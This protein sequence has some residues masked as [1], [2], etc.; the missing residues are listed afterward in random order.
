MSN[1]TANV[2]R[3]HQFAIEEY[4]SSAGDAFTLRLPVER[5]GLR[6]QTNTVIDE[7]INGSLWEV[8]DDEIIS[9]ELIS[10]SMVL[11]PRPATLQKICMCIFGDGAFSSNVKLPG[12]ICSY[13]QVGHSDPTVDKIYRYNNCVTSTAEFSASD[14]SPLLSLLWNIEGQS[15]TVTD[16]V[17]TNWPS[18]TLSSQ[19]PFVFRQG[20]LTVGGTA[21]K[22]KDFRFT[23]N[24]NLQLGDFYNSLNREE[25]PSSL[26]Q[27]ELIHTSP[28]DSGTEAAKIGTAQTDIAAT[29]NFVSGTKQLQFEFPSLYTN[30]DEPE[31][32]GRL[33]IHNQYTWRAKY[34]SADAIAA[35]VRITVVES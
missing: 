13:F 15:R 17:S 28:W 6:G 5:F 18:L 20:T 16:D 30:L 22:M 26:Q 31:I 19:Q 33:R 4:G 10:G 32:A 23:I 27:F 25:M 21:F 29:L 34:D 12:N 11:N 9:S 7:G 2:P 3:G 14:T 24:N 35:P 8:K 1:C